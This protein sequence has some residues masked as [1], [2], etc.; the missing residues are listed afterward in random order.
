MCPT[1]SSRSRTGRTSDRCDQ[2]FSICCEEDLFILSAAR[3][4]D[5]AVPS[6]PAEDH[7]RG[8][9]TKE[10]MKLPSERQKGVADDFATFDALPHGREKLLVA[11]RLTG[12]LFEAS[13]VDLT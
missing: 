4:Q 3:S 9:V 7:Y 10:G 8:A 13:Q 6:W 1:V 12:R 2:G 5:Q 11:R